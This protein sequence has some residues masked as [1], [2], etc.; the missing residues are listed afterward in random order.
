MCAAPPCWQ[1]LVVVLACIDPAEITSD[2]WQTTGTTFSYSHWQ[3]VCHNTIRMLSMRLTRTQS[4]AFLCAASFDAAA[5]DT[6]T[7]HIISWIRF[8]TPLLLCT[9]LGDRTFVRHAC[10][11]LFRF[12]LG[13]SGSFSCPFSPPSVCF[14][15]SFLPALYAV[16]Q[17]RI[18]QNY[19]S[20]FISALNFPPC[21]FLSSSS[22]M[23]A[24]LRTGIGRDVRVASFKCSSSCRF[25]WPVP[26][27]AVFLVPMFSFPPRVRSN[28]W[29]HTATCSRSG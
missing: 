18:I 23:S 13:P 28:S 17:P 1:L 6:C 26:R 22:W 7:C 3:W 2:R 16:Q 4:R 9:M 29:P 24:C 25:H 11:R 19:S 5:P 12:S 20:S 14:G 27:I 10:R 21:L 8:H 15:E